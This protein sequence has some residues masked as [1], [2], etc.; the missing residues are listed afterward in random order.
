MSD[1]GMK[2][3]A[4]YKSLIEHDP[5]LAKMKDDKD[6]IEKPKI[7][8]EVAEE[9]NEILTNYHGEELIVSFYRDGRI[10]TRQINIKRIDE[11]ER[12][13]ILS[14]KKVIHLYEIFGLERV[15]S[16]A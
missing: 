14:D 12:K 8:S 7:S 1:R 15:E 6:K 5:A 11:V 2:K 16:F 13:L 4:P 10:V 3:W 9:I